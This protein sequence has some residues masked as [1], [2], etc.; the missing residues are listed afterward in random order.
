MKL[1]LRNRRLRDWPLTIFLLASA[2]AVP[3]YGFQ[4]DNRA[5]SDLKQDY[6]AAQQAKSNGNLPQAATYTKL[7]IV[8]ALNLLARNYANV[9][10]YGEATALYEEALLLDRGDLETRLDYVQESVSEADLEKASEL[11][12]EA[13]TRAPSSAAAHL[14]LGRVLLLKNDNLQAKK[15]LEAAVALDPNYADGM[16]LARADLALKDESQAATLF[17]EMEKGFGDTAQL[18]MDIGLQYAETDYSEQATE[19]FKKAI[20]END[21]LPGAH[22]SLGASYLQNMG[23]M[24]FAKAAAEFRKELEISPN[25][26]L[27]HSQLGYMAM[28]QHDFPQAETELLRASALAPQDPDIDFMLGQL[29]IEMDQPIKAENALNRSIELTRDVSRNSYQVQRAHY[30]LARVLMKQGKV[31]EAKKQIELSNALLQQMDQAKQGKPAGPSHGE[32]AETFPSNNRSLPASIDAQQLQKANSVKEELAPAIADSYNNLGVISAIQKDY[33]QATNYFQKTAKWAP[34]LD[35]LDLNWGRAAFLD[36]Q[37][38]QA[39]AP[40][41]RYLQSHPAD[42]SAQSM[43]T[44]SLDR[45]KQKDKT[46]RKGSTN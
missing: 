16:A 37:F 20:A 18:H 32:A 36:G 35:G 15:Q 9:G 8:R 27:S 13:V 21:R 31:D 4:A 25:D 12:Q 10:D 34:G 39:I 3:A 43:L 17:G 1:L 30:L 41:Q 24:N 44:Q 7:F 2:F 46:Q 28:K 23:E 6:D 38:E 22:Y 42:D 45:T 19:Q 29:Y 11:A 33:K 14:A 5:G 26:V 40:L